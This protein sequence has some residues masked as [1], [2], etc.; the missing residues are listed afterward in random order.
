MYLYI[1]WD[2]SIAG[3]LDLAC[4]HH[5]ARPLMLE[6]GDLDGV[7]PTLRF[8]GGGASVYLL[9]LVYRKGRRASA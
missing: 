9:H 4:K 8:S 1:T 3:S 6:T 7:G 2:V 5:G